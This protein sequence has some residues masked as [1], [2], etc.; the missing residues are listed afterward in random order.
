MFSCF[1]LRIEIVYSTAKSIAQIFQF[2]AELYKKKICFIYIMYNVHAKIAT[3]ICFLDITHT[4][5]STLQTKLLMFSG[6]DINQYVNF[7]KFICHLS[8]HTNIYNKMPTILML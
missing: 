1:A 4:I 5:Q 2:D 7:C 6:V 3:K 8:A